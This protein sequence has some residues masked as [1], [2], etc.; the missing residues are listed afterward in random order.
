[1]LDQLAEAL[2]EKGITLTYKPEAVSVIA[3]ESYSAKYGARNMRRYIQ[4]HVEDKLAELI[5]ADYSHSCTQ[6]LIS[7]KDGK[8]NVVCM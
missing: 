4:T 1:M 8:L 7:A 6:A 2:R 5:I 3:H